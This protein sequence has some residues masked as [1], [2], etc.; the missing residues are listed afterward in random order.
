MPPCIVG[1]L[2]PR[3]GRLLQGDLHDYQMIMGRSV[4][5][6]LA[7][8]PVL[9]LMDHPSRQDSGDSSRPG[10]KWICRKPV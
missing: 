4:R 2:Q 6:F 10:L 9:V 7:A 8:M 3:P 5:I 1:P